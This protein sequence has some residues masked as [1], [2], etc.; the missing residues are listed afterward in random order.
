MR[1]TLPRNLPRNPFESRTEAWRQVGLGAE[2]DRAQAKR[3]RGG[4]VVLV[5]AIAAV[6]ILFSQRRNL[7]PGLGTEVRVATVAALVI[8]GWGLARLLGRGL[9]PALF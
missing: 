9:A 4:V 7:F 1:R 5:A 6:L 8:L 3:A 2:V